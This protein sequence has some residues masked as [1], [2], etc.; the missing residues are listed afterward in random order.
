MRAQALGAG[1]VAQTQSS[2]PPF[3]LHRPGSVAEVVALLA[4][5]P[6]AV[7]AAGCTDLTAQLR[8]GRVPRDLIS[9]RR[10][11]DLQ[12]V[13]HDGGVL[14]IGAGLTHHEGSRHP[15]LQATLPSLA[16]A[17]ADIATVRIRYSATIGGNLLARRFR[18]EMPVLLGALEADLE[19]AGATEPRRP[20]DW[21]W[22]G[23]DHDGGDHDGSER[24][25]AGAGAWRTRGLLTGVA[26]DTSDLLWFGYERSMRPTT[27][28]A[29]AIRV[30]DG[31]LRVTATIG[32]EYRRPV[33]VSTTADVAHPTDLDPGSV[34]RAVASRLP[35]DIEDR[36]GSAEYRRHL[37]AVL[38]GRLV[39]TARD[40]G[41]QAPEGVT[42]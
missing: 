4:V 34:G 27:T 40:S 16:A 28:V 9:V 12:Q 7:I 25:G 17:W 1:L 30:V 36:A 6:E 15:L 33:T 3:E 29:L 21:L 18:Y 37:V 5:H 41:A 23:G 22:G 32:S 19:L 14:R 38:V 35:D 2:I 11:P 20:V 10:V 13:R 26:I 24:D 42:A 8:E 39:A 31:S